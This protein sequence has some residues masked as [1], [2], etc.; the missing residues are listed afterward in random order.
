MPRQTPQC[1][2]QGGLLDKN[3]AH[4]TAVVARAISAARSLCAYEAGAIS[5][6]KDCGYENVIV[7]AIAGVPISQEG[8][9]S[10]CAHSDLMGNLIMEC[11]DL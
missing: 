7:K 6:G 9:T 2:S 10:T 3:L 1:S 4:T 5:P 8:K 11:C